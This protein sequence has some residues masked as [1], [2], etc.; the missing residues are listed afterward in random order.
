MR[1]VNINNF[2][3]YI[4]L[5]YLNPL[6]SIG[7]VKTWKMLYW[8]AEDV[9]KTCLI[10]VLLQGQVC[11]RLCRTL[12]QQPESGNQRS[13]DAIDIDIIRKAS[14][15]PCFDSCEGRCNVCIYASLWLNE[16]YPS[17]C[18]QEVLSLYSCIAPSTISASS[19]A[20]WLRLSV[21][22]KSYD[23][24]NRTSDVNKA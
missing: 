16:D 24:K 23:K 2:N 12:S 22:R 3:P 6:F 21:G 17:Q 4:D 14:T 15:V 5:R 8:D 19:S 18:L 9:P 7:K 1:R 11:S 20:A 10:S 13:L